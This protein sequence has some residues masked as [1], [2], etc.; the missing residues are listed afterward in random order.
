MNDIRSLIEKLDQI[1]ESEEVNR[2]IRIAVKK[3]GQDPS[4][5]DVEKN[6]NIVVKH[7]RDQLQSRDDDSFIQSIERGFKR[8]GSSADYIKRQHLGMTAEHLGLPGLYSMPDGK[9]Y[10]YTDKDQ[11]G[12]YKSA[13]FS[14]IEDAVTLYKA[15]YVTRDK[16]IELQ[17][18]NRDIALKNPKHPSSA[19]FSDPGPAANWHKTNPIPNEL[20]VRPIDTLPTDAQ[21]KTSNYTGQVQKSPEPG[22]NNSSAVDIGTGKVKTTKQDGTK[23]ELG[24]LITTLQ[25]ANANYISKKLTKA[26]IEKLSSFKVDE[27]S[28]ELMNELRKLLN[29]L[30]DSK[31]NFKSDI[32][33]S[34]VESDKLYE[35]ELSGPDEEK[36]KIIIHNLRLLEPKINS[37]VVRAR[38]KMYLESVPKKYLTAPAADAPAAD[39]PAA[40]AATTNKAADAAPTASNKKITWKDLAKLNPQITDPNKIYPGQEIKL[41]S[42][43]SAIVDQGDT[44]SSLAQR[45]NDGGYSDGTPVDEPAAA[46]P[47]DKAPP[48]DKS[49]PAANAA[50]AVPTLKPAEAA[51]IS[52]KIK[53]ALLSLRNQDSL[54]RIWMDIKS[55]ENFD[56]IDAQFRT[57]GRKGIIDAV[58]EEWFYNKDKQFNPMLKRLGIAVK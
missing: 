24:D 29:V 10:I 48:A 50:P 34:L 1:N 32:A 19:L 44:L 14:S 20:S 13:R 11:S 3:L 37:A 40:D 16:A 56:A 39:A 28:G 9:S 38:V 41:P 25:S 22:A 46:T 4:I 17:K 21:N 31:L 58:R 27:I 15:G 2:I 47:A 5:E 7:I 49:P 33:L 52:V 43:G 45:Y 26:D 42:G 30:N 53:T 51:A 23:D 12:N 55:K 8:F 35:K 54:D 6:L 57:T 18:D 36:L